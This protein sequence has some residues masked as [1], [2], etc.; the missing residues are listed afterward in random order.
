MTSAITEAELQQVEDFEVAGAKVKE[1][2]QKEMQDPERLARFLGRYASWNGR[3]GSCVCVLASKIGRSRSS[4][5]DPTEPVAMLAD[6]SVFVASYFFDAAR[7]EFDDRDTEHRDTHRCLAQ[8]SLS[9]IIGFN[10]KSDDRFGDAIWVNRLLRDPAWL[11]A[12]HQRTYQGYGGGSPDDNEFIFRAIGYHLGSEI[13][14]DQEFSE[15]DSALRTHAPE[16]VEHLK[17]TKVKIGDQEHVAY[18]W[19]GIHS[20][21]GGGAEAD[22]FAWAT[23]GVTL[24]LK[25]SD[26]SEHDALRDQ[27]FAGYRDFARDHD[28]FFNHVSQP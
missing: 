19:I 13:L 22:H 3:F 21:H 14:A 17:N 27:V 15:I 2:I 10:K 16:L 11:R 6:R 12:L 5:V 23:A 26:P 28:E 9:G 18:Q 20:G 4:F 24:A 25:Y 8:A 7:D 1:V